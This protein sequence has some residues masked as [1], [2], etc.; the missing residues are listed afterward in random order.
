MSCTRN[1]IRRVNSKFL[2][3]NQLRIGKHL[4]R[5]PLYASLDSGQCLGTTSQKILA[6]P[7]PIDQVDLQHDHD[8]VPS[9]PRFSTRSRPE[10]FGWSRGIGCWF[11]I[12]PSPTQFRREFLISYHYHNPKGVTEYIAP[13]PLLLLDVLHELLLPL[14]QLYILLCSSFY[15]V[16]TGIYGSIY[17]VQRAMFGATT[18]WV[19]LL[20]NDVSTLKMC[21]TKK[22]TW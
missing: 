9:L 12:P 8:Q 5:R 10:E 2:H 17:E 6:P 4:V 13:I 14:A 11:K 15:F 7:M 18:T 21:A 1:L 19:T 20:C 16:H 22:S 3:S